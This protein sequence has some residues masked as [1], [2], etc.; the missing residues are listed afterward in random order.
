MKL[1][2][3][4][5]DALQYVN[6]LGFANTNKR[7]PSWIVQAQMNLCRVTDLLVKESGG[8]PYKVRYHRKDKAFTV[9]CESGAR[10]VLWV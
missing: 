4:F 7:Y 8:Y 10:S 6:R 2:N 3:N 9:V 1:I 5:D